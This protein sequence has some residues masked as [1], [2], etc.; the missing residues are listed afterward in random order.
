MGR[1]TIDRSMVKSCVWGATP[2]MDSGYLRDDRA[3][4]SKGDWDMLLRVLLVVRKSPF[5]PRVFQPVCA[6]PA[7]LPVGL[8]VF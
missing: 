7:T 6:D 1:A 2:Q 8:D 3:R 5:L 4:L